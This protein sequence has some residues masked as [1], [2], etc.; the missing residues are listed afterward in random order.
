MLFKLFSNTKIFLN[1]I[2]LSC[3]SNIKVAYNSSKVALKINLLS[4]ADLTNKNL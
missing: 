4:K 2:F 1:N 3:L